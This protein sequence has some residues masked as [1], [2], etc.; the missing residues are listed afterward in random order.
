MS[1]RTA[2]LEGRVK[3]FVRS[4]SGN[5]AF[6]LE[7]NQGNVHYCF[8]AG[9]K[10]ILNPSDN[11]VLIGSFLSGSKFR[12]SFLLNKTKNTEENLIDTKSDWTY[13]VSLVSAIL[14][15]CGLLLYLIFGP[16][17]FPYGSHSYIYA[18]VITIMSIVFFVPIMII[19]WVLTAFFSKSRKKGSKLDR[20]ILKLKEEYYSKAPST[21]T[22]KTVDTITKPNF[23]PRCGGK[24]PAEAKFC[25]NCGS[26][27]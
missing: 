4:E 12:I 10:P 14:V 22:I 17:L 15:T 25:P 27:F 9:K 24:L 6:M 18:I 19:L 23:C 7:D 13:K 20:E 26:E 11:L 8:S 5:L 1:I 2:V 3:Q 21:S 16:L